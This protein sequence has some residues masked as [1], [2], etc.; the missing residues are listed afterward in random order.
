MANWV[1]M[2]TEGNATMR[3]LPWWQRRKSCGDDELGT[4][5]TTR[6]FP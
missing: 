2:F 5:R 3:I 6:P 4:A 1:Y